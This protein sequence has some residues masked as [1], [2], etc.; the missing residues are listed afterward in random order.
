MSAPTRIADIIVPDVFVPYVIERTAELSV[1]VQSGI[2]VPDPQLDILAAAGGT[3]I[4]MPFFKDLT[5]DDEVLSE[6]TPLDPDKISAVKDQARL[7]MRGKA[8][9]VSDLAKALS[10]DD[11]MAAIANLVAQYWNRR[12]QALLISV[13]KGVFADNLAND[14]G[15]LISNIAL[16]GAGTPSDSNLIGA[17]AVID[18]ATK[19]GD[20]AGALTAIAMHSVPYSRLQKMNLID[21]IPDSEGKVNIPTYLGKRVIVDDGCP[22]A[23]VSG[24]TQYTTY[25]FGQGAIG[26]GDGRAPVPVETDRDSLQG[27][28]YL[29]HRRHFILHPRGIKW[30][31]GSITGASPTNAECETASHWDRVYEKKNIRI[32]KL[33]TNG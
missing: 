30:V 29:I 22:T 17:T 10:G 18:G 8:W 23:S 27:E 20:A 24:N 7:L 11:P 1:L 25:L 14:A 12:E 6:T 4:Q 32:V 28:D 3:I 13:L 5:G 26:R 16:A 33:V 21:F 31:E 15:D 19:L 2:V 9:G